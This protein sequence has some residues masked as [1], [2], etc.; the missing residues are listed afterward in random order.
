MAPDIIDALLY[1][2]GSREERAIL[3]RD[4]ARLVQNAVLNSPKVSDPEVEGVVN[5]WKTQGA[6][7][8]MEEILEEG[9]VGEWEGR[10]G[11]SE[12]T[13]YQALL[14]EI[15]L[16]NKVCDVVPRTIMKAAFKGALL[17]GRK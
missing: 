14:G 10:E 5:F 17:R 15:A 16:V 4:T 12:R 2:I 6:P 11:A 7:R 9:A 13:K 3:I 1:F 8:Y